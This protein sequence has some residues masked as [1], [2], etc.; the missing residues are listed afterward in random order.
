MRRMHRASA[1]PNPLLRGVVPQ[2]TGVC[3]AS[4]EGGSARTTHPVTSCHPSVGGD[5][6]GLP[7]LRGQKPHQ[8]V[9]KAFLVRFLFQMYLLGA[10][11]KFAHHLQMLH[12]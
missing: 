5:W 4:R 12:A 2:G 7:I 1:N 9:P 3:W 10:F 8:E 6:G 11:T